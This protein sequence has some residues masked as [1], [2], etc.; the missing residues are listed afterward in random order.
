MPT[1]S[2][3]VTR[4]PCF[5]GCNPQAPPG[6]ASPPGPPEAWVALGVE[7]RV[8]IVSQFRGHV[9]WGLFV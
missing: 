8:G 7:G 5:W 9:W 2:V 1:E 4:P 3:G 6:G